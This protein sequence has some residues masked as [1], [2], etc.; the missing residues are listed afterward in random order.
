MI[1]PWGTDAPLY[2]RPFAT[3][4]LIAINVVLFFIVPGD[5]YEDYVLVLG[6]G[7]HPV[8]WLTN[9]FLHSG[10]FHL[11]G[12]MV[13]LW[14]FGLVVE[15]KLGW[16]RFLA[17]YLGLGVVDSAAM[18]ILV[19]SEQAVSMLGSST[20]LFGLMGMCLVW[21][22]RNEVSCIVWLRFT[23]MEFDLS[24]LW[25]AA[26]YIA[27]EVFSG[28][29]SG[30]LRAS[31]TNLS[32]GVIVA[33]ELDHV[34]GAVLGI[35]VGAA[36]VKL[37]WVDC[38]NWD[39]FAVLERREGRPKGSET[40]TRKSKRRMST[41]SGRPE[42]RGRK[43][44]QRERGV[45]PSAE[46]HASAALRALRHQLEMGEIEVAL[47]V[48][49]KARGSS[50]GWQPPEREWRDLIEALLSHESWDDAVLV[51]RDYLRDLAEPS[52]RVRLKLAQV[53]IQKHGRPQ[54]ALKVLSRIPD[55]SLPEKL[56]TL[57]SQLTRRAETMREEG[58]LELDEDIV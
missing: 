54:Q 4:A 26:I 10:I 42:R 15:G 30:I 57:R 39:L 19:P 7:V 16:L 27:M 12:N 14:T 8:Q 37:G 1:I 18:Q 13:F 6:D 9:N 28:G 32:P 46:D 35:V 49:Q 23:P 20:I 24:I 33:I 11:L 48:Y 41:E 5:A 25:F 53:L 34:F 40:L 47:A 45:G 22:P 2:H 56:E 29:M 58:P 55:G 43:K 44:G 31:L 3:I 38:E 36:M 52:P 50:A 17:V 51:M 21:A